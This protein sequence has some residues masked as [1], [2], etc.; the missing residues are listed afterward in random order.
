MSDIIGDVLDSVFQVDDTFT[1]N[2]AA[3]PRVVVSPMQNR[4]NAAQ[5]VFSS[6]GEG[7]N[8][9]YTLPKLKYSF[10][11]EFILSTYAKDFIKTQLLDTHAR[12]DIYNVSCFVRDVNLPSA[13][14]EVDEVNQY[15]RT[16]YQTGKIT[17]KPVS[18][19]FYDTVDS[20]A[21]LLFDAYK[22]YY[23]GDFFN[24]SPISF[25]N[26]VL[27]NP[28]QFEKTG[29]N[30]GRSVMNNG[31]FDSQYFFQQINIYEIDNETY[32]AHNM[33]NVYIEDI[34]PET[35]TM[36]S[37]GEPGV[38]QATLKYEGM[39]NLNPQG[40]ASIAVP[41]LEIG[42]LITDTSGLG[43]AG[44]YQYFGAMDD[45]SVGLS[46]IGKIIRAGTAGHDI[47]S[48]IGDI[49]RG[50]ISPDVIRNIGS[51]VSKGSSAIGLGSVISSANDAFGLGNILGDF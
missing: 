22:K 6:S 41:T 44:F 7:G 3:S 42:A 24:K 45:T 33:F 39:G 9:G 14:F 2:A 8:A 28:V 25:R 46:T 34:T 48:S 37:E 17:Y 31:N 38:L 12:F 30:W 20:A 29:G 1:T 47:I 23:Y 18:I 15:N 21:M 50:D 51:A 40:Y 49:L 36:E 5:R 27:S 26:D 35:K 10:I 43:K 11:V 19:S 13:S 32:T 4:L 16:R